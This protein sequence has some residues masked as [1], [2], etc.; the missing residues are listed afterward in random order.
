MIVSPIETKANDLR[1][2]AGVIEKSKL[3]TFG[4]EVN[5]AFYLAMDYLG[6]CLLMVP[7]RPGFDFLKMQSNPTENFNVFFRGDPEVFSAEAMSEAHSNAEWKEALLEAIYQISDGERI[8]IGV[9]STPPLVTSAALNVTDILEK[10]GIGLAVDRLRPC[11]AFTISVGSKMSLIH[12]M[13]MLLS[14]EALLWLAEEGFNQ[15][16][17]GF[18]T[19]N[20]EKVFVFDLSQAARFEKIKDEFY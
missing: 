7:G 3:K 19:R 18:P 9:I 17:G 10:V 4:D 5:A 14:P 20:S 11:Y 16:V 2:A 13:D 12:Y 8:K 15:S 6:F 1:V